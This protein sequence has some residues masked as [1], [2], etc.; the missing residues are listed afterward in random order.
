MF[1]ILFR[2]N[3]FTLERLRQFCE[4]ADAG[5][6]TDAVDQY[7]RSQPTYSRS[8]SALEEFF[9]GDLFIQKGQ[10]RSGKKLTG[11]TPR[12][13]SLRRLAIN[14]FED[15]TGLLDF[16]ETP[17]S[18]TIGAGE[19]VM[20]WVILARLA[21]IRGIQPDVPVRLHG[22]SSS[23]ILSQISHGRLDVGIIENSA[24]TNLPDDISSLPLGSINYALYLNEEMAKQAQTQ[25]ENELLNTLPVA[26]MEDYHPK[27]AFPL[28]FVVVVS[29]YPQLSA[30]LQTG[31]LAG[32]LPVTAE[33]EMTRLN[34]TKIEVPYL[35]NLAVPISLI[36]NQREAEMRPFV[37][38]A[39]SRIH[40]LLS[41]ATPQ[42]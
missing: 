3:G 20:Q 23:T 41:E 18:L 37:A 31:G 13:E 29:S 17:S 15:T 42:P 12:G 40:T 19:T 24:L 7:G 25:S 27:A 9:D 35:K 8:I 1:E 11:L 38:T 22:L 16:S 21:D 5:S 26:R 36:W 14:F 32:F 33:E 6:I 10:S 2:T 28:N 4:V 39:A 34:L 30:A